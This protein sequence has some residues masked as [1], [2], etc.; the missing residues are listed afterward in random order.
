MRHL[1]I[2][3]W[4][5]R[6]KMCSHVF[7]FV[8][9]CPCATQ[10]CLFPNRQHV[11]VYSYF[12][13]KDDGG[14]FNFLPSCCGDVSPFDGEKKPLLFQRECRHLLVGTDILRGVHLLKQTHI[15]VSYSLFFYQELNNLISSNVSSAV[16]LKHLNVIVV[17]FLSLRNVS[18]CY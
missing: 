8:P 10:K 6:E 2:R 14:S 3:I 4:G 9:Q 1:I 17:V 11:A 7:L 13:V 12:V 5:S 18:Y 15:S 16:Y